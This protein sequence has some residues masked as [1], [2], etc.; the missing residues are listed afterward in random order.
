MLRKAIRKMETCI[1]GARRRT[2]RFYPCLREELVKLRFRK[3]KYMTKTVNIRAKTVT[4]KAKN[5]GRQLTKGTVHVCSCPICSV[6]TLLSFGF[7]CL[8]R[9]S[10]FIS[11]WIL[12]Y[13]FTLFFYEEQQSSP[14]IGNI[15]SN[16]LKLYAP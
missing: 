4:S 8:P 1:L 3:K 12:R 7:C 15:S 11:R 5:T 6:E 13:T 2:L 14:E 16:P 9:L 10:H